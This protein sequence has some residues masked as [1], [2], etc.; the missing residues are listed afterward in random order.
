MK[1]LVPGLRPVRTSETSK[2]AL[3]RRA[4]AAMGSA[5]RQALYESNIKVNAAMVRHIGPF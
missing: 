4:W 5:T 3:A 1:I 2:P